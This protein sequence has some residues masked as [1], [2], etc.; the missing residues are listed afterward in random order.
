MSKLSSGFNSS[1]VIFDGRMGMIIDSTAMTLATSGA[2]DLLNGN[3][4]VPFNAYIA[5]LGMLKV[6]NSA[7]TKANAKLS[8]GT[9]TDT[10]CF[11][12]SFV[13]AT[14]LATSAA[15]QGKK[16][17]MLPATTVIFNGTRT[18]VIPAGSIVVFEFDALALS[19]TNRMQFS[20]VV[21]PQDQKNDN[22]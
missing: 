17:F 16:F 19:A 14:Y 4:L 21:M 11:M 12:D 10:D 8:I 18:N 7:G 22:V 2:G 9:T 1:A 13:L 15:N 20:L 5:A 3:V 6:N